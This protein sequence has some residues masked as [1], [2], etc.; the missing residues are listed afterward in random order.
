MHSII[1]PVAITDQTIEFSTL[2]A[3]VRN[4]IKSV[5]HIKYSTH[6]AVGYCND[7]EAF[8]AEGYWNG[9]RF[10][11]LSYGSHCYQWDGQ[12]L[13]NTERIYA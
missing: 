5:D 13:H 4:E 6:E 8:S 1:E 7:T 9:N 10:Q 12:A 2:P 3:R 11:V